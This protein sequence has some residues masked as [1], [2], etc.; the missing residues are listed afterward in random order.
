MNNPAR[1]YLNTLLHRKRGSYGPLWIFELDPETWVVAWSSLLGDEANCRL[2]LSEDPN[3]FNREWGMDGRRPNPTYRSQHD[4]LQEVIRLLWY[5]KN[6]LQNDDAEKTRYTVYLSEAEHDL[7][8]AL[9]NQQ[10]RTA[11]GDERTNQMSQSAASPEDVQAVQ[12]SESAQPPAEVEKTPPAPAPQVAEAIARPKPWDN[13][14][15]KPK[16]L[17]FIPP[18]EL[19]AKMEWVSKNVPGGMSR[20]AILREGAEMLCDHL[21]AKHYRDE[22]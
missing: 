18:A 14:T 9:T 4:V 1:T 2:I 21:I 7:H 15:E 16:G 17:S 5:M 12:A 20:L 19:H 22:K 11:H 8:Q 10:S 6:E 13:P 3:W